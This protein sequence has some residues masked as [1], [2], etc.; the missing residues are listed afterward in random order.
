MRR[1]PNSGSHVGVPYGT[2]NGSCACTVVLLLCAAAAPLWMAMTV[3]A[4]ELTWGAW[5][6]GGEGRG[7]GRTW[8][9]RGKSKRAQGEQAGGMWV[10]ILWMGEKAAAL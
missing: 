7:E 1:A 2:W 9:D 6:E 4:D 8:R 3:D 10:G 5:E